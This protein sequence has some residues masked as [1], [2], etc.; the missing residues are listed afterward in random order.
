MSYN[1]TKCQKFPVQEEYTRCADCDKEHQELVKTLNAKYKNQLND[2]PPKEVLIPFKKIQQGVEVTT[3]YT[4]DECR[5][6]GL[7]VPPEYE[8]A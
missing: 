1:C 4:K 7:K 2:V 5:I 3:W 6:W 8:N